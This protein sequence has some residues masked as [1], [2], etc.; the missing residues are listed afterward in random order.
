MSLDTAN[1]QVFSEATQ[2]A[3]GNYSSLGADEKLAFLYYVYKKMGKSITPAAPAAADPELAPLLLENFFNL[4]G[5]DQLAVMREVVEGADTEYSQAYGSLTA[6]NQ[7]LVW[8]AWAQGM[9]KTV[10]DMPSSYKPAKALN[11][12]VSQIEGLDFQDQISVLREI[13]SQMGHTNV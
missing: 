13:A 12:A 2:N 6:N 5:E 8:Y 7:L 1:S 9:G 11:D 3:F 10:I 4:S